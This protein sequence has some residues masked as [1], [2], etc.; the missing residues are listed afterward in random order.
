MKIA[1][2]LSARHPQEKSLR[3]KRRARAAAP[4]IDFMQLNGYYS[5]AT[6]VARS[7]SPVSCCR[8]QAAMD[9]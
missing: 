6:S 7:Q 9:K 3:R 1:E 4:G 8:L 5:R 2:R